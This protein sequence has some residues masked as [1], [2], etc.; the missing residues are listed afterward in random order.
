MHVN[1][2]RCFWLIMMLVLAGC[3]QSGKRSTHS[4]PLLVRSQVILIDSLK[5]RSAEF[6]AF[7]EPYEEQ[8]R[9]IASQDIGRLAKS[10]GPSPEFASPIPLF[11]E[12]IADQFEER[13]GHRPVAI[14]MEASLHS[15]ELDSGVVTLGQLYEKIPPGR[16]LV[17]LELTVEQFAAFADGVSEPGDLTLIRLSDMNATPGALITTRKI[18]SS[19]SGILTEQQ[20]VEWVTL[21]LNLRRALLSGFRK[22]GETPV[23]HFYQPAEPISAGGA[24]GS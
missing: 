10:F 19:S 12:I 22:A 24:D 2:G 6:D 21:D 16:E 13:S 4:R 1:C 15:I 5:D 23:D 9:H 14:L 8:V 18:A 17:Y 20:E 11:A 7:L 3:G